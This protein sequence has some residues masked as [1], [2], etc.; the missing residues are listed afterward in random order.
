MTATTPFR[1]RASELK[2]LAVR[3]N[4]PAA[5]HALGHFG[6]IA[7]AGVAVWHSLGTVWAAPLTILLGYMLA[8]LFN[9]EHEAAHQTAFHTR[10]YNNLLGHAAGLVIVLPY[11]YYRVFHWDHHR[12]TQD[13][14][15]DPEL[16]MPLPESRLGLFW[17]MTGLPNWRDRLRMLFV[18]GVA[19]RVTARWVPAEQ[20]RSIVVEARC[21]LAVYAVVIAASIATRS[22]AALWLWIVP[23]MIGQLFLRPYLL[24]EHTGCARSSNMLENTRTTYTNAFVRFFAWN[25]PYHVEHHAYPAV[26]FHALP[27]LNALLGE[28]ITHN[29]R[30][31][32]AST[33]SALSHLRARGQSVVAPPPDP[34]SSPS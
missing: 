29:G 26:P 13:P 23:V 9:A 33:A 2:P 6:A 18:H 31:Y 19:G 4:G 32:R 10:L 12:Y 8:F 21:Y 15:R 34:P 3:S 25:M 5:R 28:H 14:D 16:A 30:G 17:Y 20:R 11:G 7:L 27:K 22:L 24:A 1:L